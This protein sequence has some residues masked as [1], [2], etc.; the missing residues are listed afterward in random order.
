MGSR[1]D[2][3]FSYWIFV[4]FLI[5]ACGFPSYNPFFVLL[6]GLVDNLIGLGMLI[7]YQYALFDIVCSIIINFFIKVIPILWMIMYKK[8]TVHWQ[9]IFF[10]FGLY[11]VFL[12]WLMVN[13]VP[14][15]SQFHVSKK[16]KHLDTPLIHLIRKHSLHLDLY[17]PC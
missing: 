12:G 16:K 1:F 11:C 13:G 9:D 7:Y 2:Y 15:L 3:V 10:T 6:I 14:L 17:L 5:F 4:W 8:A